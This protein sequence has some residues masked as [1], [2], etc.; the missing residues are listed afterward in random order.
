MSAAKDKLDQLK[1]IIYT[2]AET[3][4]KARACSF[5]QALMILDLSF[6]MYQDAPQ[7]LIDELAAGLQGGKDVT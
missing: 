4:Q 1:A 3:L 6:R 2:E 7:A 5:D